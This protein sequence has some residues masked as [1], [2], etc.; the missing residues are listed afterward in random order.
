MPNIILFELLLYV[1]SHGFVLI[2][3][4][5]AENDIEFMDDREILEVIDRD[6]VLVIIVFSKVVNH[7]GLRPVG[8]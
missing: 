1:I 7:K 8:K 4:S 2:L 5:P 3:R 6:W